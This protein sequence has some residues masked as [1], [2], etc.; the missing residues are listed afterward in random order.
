[1]STDIFLFVLLSFIYFQFSYFIKS[2]TLSTI[3]FCVYFLYSLLYIGLRKEFGSDYYNYLSQ[4]ND[5]L[6]DYGGYENIYKLIVYFNDEITGIPE[7]H[8]FIITFLSLWTLSLFLKKSLYILP[9]YMINFFGSFTG[10]IRTTLTL[11]LILAAANVLYCR[12]FLI[13]IFICILLVNIHYASIIL[14]FTMLLL[15]T[16]NISKYDKKDLSIYF[17][18][19]IA[20]SLVT[21]F[22]HKIIIDQ[23]YSL[24]IS[25][26]YITGKI[27]SYT[28][29]KHFVELS[30]TSIIKKLFIAVFLY[31]FLDWSKN[32]AKFYFIL[33]LSG[34]FYFFTFGFIFGTLGIRISTM[35]SFFEILLL[36]KYVNYK[37]IHFKYLYLIAIFIMC[38]LTLY[39]S[40][41]QYPDLYS[42]Y[43][44]LWL[45]L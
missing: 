9:F 11:G 25:F 37:I 1:M 16:L 14:I 3:I 44:N 45:D 7:F 41:M 22:Y 24:F 30:L 35:F 26:D 6:N 29:E 23:I 32:I 5:V 8:F 20:L 2:Q 12:R 33:L 43:K 18:L 38:C 27:G 21:A 40:V 10:S 34:Y 4:Y 31:V 19:L 39:S 15:N 36:I 17:F 28:S 42:N 13:F